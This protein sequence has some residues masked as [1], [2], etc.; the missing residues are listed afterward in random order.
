M[1][2]KGSKATALTSKRVAQSSNS[3]SIM[4][5]SV[6]LPGVASRR[7]L[8][9]QPWYWLLAAENTVSSG[10]KW[11]TK[12]IAFPSRS[13]TMAIDAI[14]TLLARS[15]PIQHG[16]PAKSSRHKLLSAQRSH[17]RISIQAVS[18]LTQSLQ[19]LVRKL[20]VAEG[21]CSALACS[22]PM[23]SGRTEIF[24]LGLALIR[25]SSVPQSSLSSRP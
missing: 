12:A 6:T 5:K 21:S 18:V 13:N 25:A 10:R 17:A 20:L 7:P 16:S 3:A 24:Q 1:A 19:C 9:I 2:W 8:F 15:I 14:S 4:E 11:R 22:G 23:T